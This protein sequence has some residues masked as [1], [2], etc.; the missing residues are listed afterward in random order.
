MVWNIEGVLLKGVTYDSIS[1]DT[2][3]VP[4]VGY[5]GCLVGQGDMG[6]NK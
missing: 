5:I 4:V 3:I 6:L 1:R 2:G